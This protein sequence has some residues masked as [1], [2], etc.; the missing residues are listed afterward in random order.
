MQS[1]WVIHS[2]SC[3][4]SSKCSLSA[5]T[6][7]Q[8]FASITSAMYGAREVHGNEA[9]AFY[10]RERVLSAMRELRGVV[11]AREVEVAADAWPYPTYE[12]M[13]FSE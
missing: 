6:L 5:L 4:A 3:M 9:L 7:I 8:V 12:E 10:C 1:G 13:L 11:D 2:T